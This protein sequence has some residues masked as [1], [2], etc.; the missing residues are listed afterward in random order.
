M[1]RIEINQQPFYLRHEKS[2]YWPKQKML[3]VADTHFAKDAVFRDHG[4]PIRQGACGRTLRR[5]EK[6]IVDTSSKRVVI[7]GDFIHG[8]LPPAHAFY[9]QFNT[10][11]AGL[12]QVEFTILLGN[13]DRHLETDALEHIEFRD[14]LI[15]DDFVLTHEPEVDD[16]GYVLGG[17]IHP[18]A[19]LS[20]GVDRMRL[21]VFWLQ[22]KVGVLPSFGEF[23][24]GYA[25]TPKP[26]D[27]LYACGDSVIRIK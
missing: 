20:D 15:I 10:W 7:L 2:L 11:R 17:H 26:A 18:V 27:R 16:R 12:P 22:Q 19:N 14:E 3:L 9:L 6:E 25:V 5:L 8:R 13:H 21:P 23:T 24:G 1:T 4:I